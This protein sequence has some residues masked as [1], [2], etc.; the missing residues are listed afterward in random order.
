MARDYLAL[1]D[2]VRRRGSPLP[3][4]RSAPSAT[5]TPNGISIESNTLRHAGA[6]NHW[7]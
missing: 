7:R 2:A 1:Y 3:E 4:P 6:N 5:P